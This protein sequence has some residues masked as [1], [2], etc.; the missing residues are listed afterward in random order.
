MANTEKAAAVADVVATRNGVK[1]VE[2]GN[3]R[4]GVTV[5]LEPDELVREQV[6]GFTNF[7]REYAVVGLAVGFI[8]GQQANAVMKQLVTSFIDP[9]LQVLFGPGLNTRTAFVHHGE[10]PI[11]VPWGAFV[12]SFI[13]FLLVA[14]T[15][16][17]IVKLFRLDK[18]KKQ[19]EKK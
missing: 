6:G 5:L 4:K 18:L 12:Y 16:Y 3:H 17:L 14:V 2:R 10:T 13:E 9:W 7:L 19:K 11:E 8:V 15:I 1:I